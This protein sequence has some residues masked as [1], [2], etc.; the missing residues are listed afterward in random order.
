MRSG[1][2]V[3][4]QIFTHFCIFCIFLYFL[5]NSVE[6]WK[7]S[8]FLTLLYYNSAK[9]HKKKILRIIRLCK[10]CFINIMAYC[11]IYCS[12]KVS[13]KRVGVSKLLV[14]WYYTCRIFCPSLP[15]FIELIR[16]F[17][18]PC[19]IF[20]TFLPHIFKVSNYYK[21]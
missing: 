3:H 4:Y 21:P 15:H 17:S 8:F 14:H 16:I 6:I 20:F 12:A 5:H 2:R 11:N 1:F 13:K 19:L 10:N 18:K 9:F 7:K